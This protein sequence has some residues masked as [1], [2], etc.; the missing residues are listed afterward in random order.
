MIPIISLLLI[1]TI[2]NVLTVGFEQILLQQPS[3][4]SDAAEVIDTFVYFRGIAGG[5]WGLASAA[6][7][8]K[9]VIGTILVVAANTVAKRLGTGGIF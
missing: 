5:D 4:G 1:L 6:G 8:I 7:L 3:V 9:G 2:G